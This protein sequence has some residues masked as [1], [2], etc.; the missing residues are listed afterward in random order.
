MGGEEAKAE[1]VDG[2]TEGQEEDERRI[3]STDGPS[4]VHDVASLR[5]YRPTV[6][7]D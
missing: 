2:T 6:D 5:L 7:I 1:I 3:P 4:A